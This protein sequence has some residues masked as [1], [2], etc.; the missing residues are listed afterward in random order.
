MGRC[1]RWAG[2]RF[3]VIAD[4]TL[5]QTRKSAIINIRSILRHILCTRNI[6]MTP[7]CKVGAALPRV[8]GS[9]EMHCIGN[10]YGQV[11]VQP[12]RSGVA[13]SDWSSSRR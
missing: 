9:R 2:S 4:N 13:D 8:S 3:W 10:V 11:G 7:L 5:I 6:E 1:R 12:A